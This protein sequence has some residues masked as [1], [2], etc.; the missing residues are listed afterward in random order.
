SMIAV[1]FI[2]SI[3]A[4]NAYSAARGGKDP[5][6]V[7][8]DEVIGQW[9]ALAGATHLSSATPWIL[10]FALFRLFDIYKPPPV[11]QLEKLPGGTGIVMDDVMAGVYGAVVMRVL[12]WN[13]LY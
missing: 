13:N 10:A 12:G 8:V 2:P 1:M 3:W 6:E 4:A 11:R 7:V 5:Q 9:I